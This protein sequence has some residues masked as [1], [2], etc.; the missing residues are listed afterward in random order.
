M[1]S[2]YVVGQALNSMWIVGIF[3]AGGDT[4]F[5]MILDMTTMWFG[6]ILLGA[7]SSFCT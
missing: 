1:M 7:T 2:Y 5:G 4:L 6:S 3:R